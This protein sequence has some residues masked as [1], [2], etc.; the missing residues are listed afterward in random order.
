MLQIRGQAAPSAPEATACLSKEPREGTSR[1]PLG[2]NTRTFLGYELFHPWG[3]LENSGLKAST[4]L[5]RLKGWTVM[6]CPGR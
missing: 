5:L 2:K 6:P 3:E 4:S 1:A